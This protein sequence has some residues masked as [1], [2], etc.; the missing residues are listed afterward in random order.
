MLDKVQGIKYLQPYANRSCH[1]FCVKY[2]SMYFNQYVWTV[3]S[4]RD[5]TGAKLDIV[6]V[7]F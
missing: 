1:M 2:D 3:L 5:L 7:P 6:R 4:D